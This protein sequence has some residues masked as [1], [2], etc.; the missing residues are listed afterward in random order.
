MD[1]ITLTGPGGSTTLDQDT[2]QPVT[3]LRNPR[4]G[5]IRAILRGAE[6]APQRVDATLSTL[7]LGP[8]LERLTSRGIPDPEAWT[9]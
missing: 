8:G 4:N 9:Q 5:Q 1:S 2:D 6:A 7:S 3:I